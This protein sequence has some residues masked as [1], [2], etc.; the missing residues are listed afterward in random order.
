M[1]NVLVLPVYLHV[2]HTS[3][4]QIEEEL[5]KSSS[6]KKKLKENKKNNKTYVMYKLDYGFDTAISATYFKCIRHFFLSSVFIW[7]HHTF[8][9]VEV[10]HQTKSAF[11]E[12]E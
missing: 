1:K 12:I 6:K 9:E 10:K 4:S 8:I 5:E 3:E 2:V 11:N 7:I